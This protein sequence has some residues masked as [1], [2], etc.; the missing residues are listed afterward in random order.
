MLLVVAQHVR[1]RPPGGGEQEL[2]HV[3]ERDPAGLVAVAGQAVVVGRALTR[4]HGP[5]VQRHGA[6]LDERRERLEVLVLG[7]VVVEEQAIDAD[8]AVKRD[9]LAEVLASHR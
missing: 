9:P 4:E 7:G 3:Q 1:Q 6:V 5:L 2:V 8:H